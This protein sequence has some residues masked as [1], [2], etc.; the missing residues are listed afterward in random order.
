M[1][2]MPGPDPLLLE[3]ARG[4]VRQTAAGP[5]DWPAVSALREALRPM[6]EAARAALSESAGKPGPEGELATL[7]LRDLFTPWPDR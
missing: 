3:K 6:R 2:A 4:L 7:L 1:A 5:R